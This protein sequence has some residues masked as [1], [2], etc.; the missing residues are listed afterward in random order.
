ML[1]NLLLGLCILGV[2]RYGDYITAECP[3]RNYA[4]PRV[5]DVDHKHYPRKECEDAKRK[6][7]IWKKG[8][9]SNKEKEK[10]KIEEYKDAKTEQESR[11]DST[12]VQPVEQFHEKTVAA[13]KSKGL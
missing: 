1:W 8:W 5:C 3:L 7:N 13:D 12:I 10:E 11:S 4:C 6:R 2:A 9:S